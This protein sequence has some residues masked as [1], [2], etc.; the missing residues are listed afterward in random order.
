MIKYEDKLPAI[1][2]YALKRAIKIKFRQEV[3]FRG[4]GCRFGIPRRPRA[5]GARMGEGGGVHELGIVFHIIKSVED[6]AAEAP[7]R[8]GSRR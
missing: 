3:G 2:K 4:A 7:H 6:I 5:G 8:A 1:G